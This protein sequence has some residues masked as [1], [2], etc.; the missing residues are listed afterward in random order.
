VEATDRWHR[1]FHRWRDP[2][3]S[4]LVAIVHPWESGRDNSCDWDQALSTVRVD[5][6]M[7]YR[8][9]DTTHVDPGQR[10]TSADYDRYLA[11]LIGFR[12]L[13]WDPSSV[14]DRSPFRVVD[15]GFNA[16]LIR[17]D[18]AIAR[19]AS[20][21]GDAPTAR[22]A[23]RRALVGAA[24]LETLWSPRHG[25]YVCCD[26]ANGALVDS[27]SVGGLLP[28]LAPVGDTKLDALCHRI[29]DSLDRV[30]FGV[31]SQD[32]AD[33]RFDPVRYWRGPAWLITDVLLAK[34]LR[35][36][37]RHDT[38]ERVTNAALASVLVSGCAEYHDPRTGA[39]L[40]G[41]SFSWTAAMV[42]ELLRGLD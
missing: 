34:G 28:V 15:P 18:Q 7:P 41:R 19:L 8:R 42:I 13:G 36:A 1:W 5:G 3:G 9:R 20:D 25:Q 35:E 38:A 4:G 17:S 26:L 37:G 29:E 27:A 2:R 24:A 16:L 31:A 11:L 14:H 39:G 12:Q 6:L 32:P 10:P 23:D 22:A 30:P 21:L 40:G 33:P